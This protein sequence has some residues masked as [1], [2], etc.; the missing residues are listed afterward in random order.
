[1]ATSS[2]SSALQTT[3]IVKLQDHVLASF[4]ENL[5]MPFTK[6]SDRLLFD[7][8]AAAH[9]WPNAY[10][11]EFPPTTHATVP[12]LRIVAG[13]PTIVHGARTVR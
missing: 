11:K 13:D 3:A 7:S 12:N 10:A 5:I 1:M 4:H 9:V 6:N 8:G 2:S